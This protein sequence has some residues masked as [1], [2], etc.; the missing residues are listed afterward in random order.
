MKKDVEKIIQDGVEQGK[1]EREAFKLILADAEKLMDFQDFHTFDEI[2]KD[3]VE[4]WLAKVTEDYTGKYIDNAVKLAFSYPDIIKLNQELLKTMIE[5]LEE[6]ITQ[7]AREDILA[8]VNNIK[9][10]QQQIEAI[11]LNQ[12]TFVKILE[13][14]NNLKK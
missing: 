10:F 1:K 14:L 2:R 11:E 7:Q 5:E 9:N 6:N 13:A 12:K 3:L 4:A 8:H